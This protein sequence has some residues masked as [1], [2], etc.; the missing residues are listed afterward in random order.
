MVPA[1]DRPDATVARDK[2]EQLVNRIAD[3]QIA[4]I[5]GI[6]VL[7]DYGLATPALTCTITLK[8]GSNLV[9]K[10]AKK[11]DGDSYVLQASGHDLL[12]NVPSWKVTPL[13]KIKTDD[14]FISNKKP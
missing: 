7:P 10:F 12:F 5:A 9:F 13:L 8:D 14:L 3:L 6:K 2:V 4:S 1:M 11:K